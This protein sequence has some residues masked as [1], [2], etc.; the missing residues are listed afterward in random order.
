VLDGLFISP[1]SQDDQ[2]E[3]LEIVE[4]RH[5]RKATVITGQLP[6]KACMMP[7]KTYS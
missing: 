2:R 1:L 6:I 5:D 7:C 3:L 4:E